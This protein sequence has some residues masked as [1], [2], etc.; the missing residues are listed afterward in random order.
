MS[1]VNK[2]YDCT[3][4]GG[5]SFPIQLNIYFHNIYNWITYLIKSEN[6][7]I[8]GYTAPCDDYLNVSSRATVLPASF[9]TAISAGK[10]LFAYRP[11]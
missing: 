2:T 5:E 9:N 3:E 1:A 8:S 7:K 11:N 4:Q 6:V 10:S